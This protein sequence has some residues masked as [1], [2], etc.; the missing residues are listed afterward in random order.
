MESPSPGALPRVGVIKGKDLAYFMCYS[1]IRLAT[2]E[3][4]IVGIVPEPHEDWMKQLENKI[5][6][7]DFE[8]LTTEGSIRCRS[9]LGRTLNYYHR[10]AA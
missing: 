3:A 5:I 8:E 7:P 6:L 1:W 10:E 9:R 2:R 4:K